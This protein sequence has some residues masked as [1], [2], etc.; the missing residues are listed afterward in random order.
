ML[1]CFS[2]Y[3]QKICTI[4]DCIVD[5]ET[6]LDYYGKGNQSGFGGIDVQTEL[7][8][9]L[10]S[11]GWSMDWRSHG[12]IWFVGF[13]WLWVVVRF[14]C[15]L[16]VSFLFFLLW[17]VVIWFDCYWFFLVRQWMWMW[18]WVD[19]ESLS[20]SLLL[21]VVAVDLV[22]GRWRWWWVDVVWVGG[23]DGWRCWE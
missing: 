1:F 4:K 2:I 16:W 15:G 17:L 18:W 5:G 8:G 10:W 19:V 6:L 22:S 13:F 3:N 11:T 12:P 23:C 14:G 7:G 9:Q 20:L 21:F